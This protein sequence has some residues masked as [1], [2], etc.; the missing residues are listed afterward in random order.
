MGV[1]EQM[2]GVWPG[3]F[4]IYKYS[5]QV[6]MQNWVTLLLLG[7]LS[8]AVSGVLNALFP[9]EIAPNG[10]AEPS[11]IATLL[12]FLT[13]GAISIALISTQFA[14]IRLEKMSLK[15]AFAGLTLRRYGNYLLAA[16]IV[17]VLMSISMFLFLIPFFFVAPRLALFGQF[18]VEKDMGALEAIEA[19]WRATKGNVAKLYAMVGVAILFALLVIVLFGFYLLFMYSAVVTLLYKYIEKNQ[20]KVPPADSP[21]IATAQ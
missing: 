8:V 7:V 17:A 12:S 5:K 21:L 9:G 18:I 6:V 16:V 14:G 1:I 13:S 3:A 15:Q 19:S 11:T 10:D 4:G 2:G 20:T